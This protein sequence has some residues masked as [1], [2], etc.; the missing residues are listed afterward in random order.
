MLF[1]SMRIYRATEDRWLVDI[2]Y[3][4]FYSFI[5]YYNLKGLLK[6]YSPYPDSQ[7]MQYIESVYLL[8]CDTSLQEY[9]L[10][11][12]EWKKKAYTMIEDVI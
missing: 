12:I 7:T 11:S 5:N 6:F 2:Y 9:I 3:I 8:H 1:L 10:N 4:D